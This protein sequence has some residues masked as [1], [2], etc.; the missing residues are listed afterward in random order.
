MKALWLGPV[1]D[2]DTLRESIAVSPAANRWQLS[3]I[4]ALQ[5]R[6]VD[7]S[8]VGHLPDPV[9]PRG[10][11][12][13]QASDG[14]LPSGVHGHLTGYSNVPALRNHSLSRGYCRIVGKLGEQTGP[15]G[16]VI[17]Y[18]GPP[19]NAAAARLAR[20]RHGLPWVCIVADDEAPQGADGYV[21]LSWGYFQSFESPKP[22]LHLEGGVSRTTAP[23]QRR[24]RR[25][26]VVMYT[27]ALTPDGGAAFLARAFHGIRD[28]DV[29]LWILGKG[30]NPEIEQLARIDA[31][32]RLLGFVSEKEL[33]DL[34]QQ[35]S[36]FVNPR[37]S[38][39]PQN[40]RN[41]P[42]K[43][44]EYLPYGTPVVSTWT[45]G[46]D[47]EYR[48]VL[49]VPERETEASLGAAITSV[50]NWDEARR[51]EQAEKSR[52]FLEKRLWTTQ[53]A[54]LMRWVVEAGVLRIED[55]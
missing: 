52:R 25:R 41:F 15:T 2:E 51:E 53:A 3:L 20:E 26:N 50:L 32:L 38:A 40:E 44:L 1:F 43:L 11:L 33:H 21:F 30:A 9:W 14:Q 19:Y 28:P 4:E 35:A 16:L 24:E 48:G 47:P 17:T 42:S 39:I 54:R 5:G 55:R 23:R 37:P 46:L 34:M 45:A 31:R 18:N 10:R 8:V 12:R 27:G 36:V 6:G 22:K 7:V 29:E 49:V 13:L